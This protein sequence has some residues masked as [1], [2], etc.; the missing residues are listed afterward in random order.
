[1]DA[2][3]LFEKAL[4]E[5]DRLVNAGT[6]MGDPVEMGDRVIV[7]VAAFG[8]GFGAGAGGSESNG[9]AGTG[10]GGGVSPVAL[11]VIEKNVSGPE[12]IR[13]VPLRKPG[14][15]TEAITAVGEDILPK[16]VE[17]IKKEMGKEEEKEKAEVSEENPEE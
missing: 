8:F 4:A 6:V 16:V 14:V 11:V 12:G 5:I 10:A 2:D 17:I 1:M 3:N 15:V 13:V 9:G 7:P